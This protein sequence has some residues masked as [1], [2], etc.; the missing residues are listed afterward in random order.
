MAKIKK[1]PKAQIGKMI[2][3]GLK[4]VAGEAKAIKAGIKEGVSKYESTKFQNKLSSWKEGDPFPKRPLKEETFTY[5][6]NGRNQYG[7]Y[8]SKYDGKGGIMKKKMK[9]GGSLSGLT[10]SNKRDKGIDP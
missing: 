4:K 8:N 7:A 9:N 2:R 1:A 6:K 10:A 3:S 5:D